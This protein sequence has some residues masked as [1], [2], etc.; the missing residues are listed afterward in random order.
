MLLPE[1]EQCCFICCMDFINLCFEFRG[2]CVSC[3]PP[4]GQHPSMISLNLDSRN[5]DSVSPFR[6]GTSTG[7]PVMICTGTL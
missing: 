2:P 6:V 1:L 5:M 7:E 4:E 3:K